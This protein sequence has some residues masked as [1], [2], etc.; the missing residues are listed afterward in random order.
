MAGSRT[1]KTSS[2]SPFSASGLKLPTPAQAALGRSF[3]GTARRFTVV[4]RTLAHYAG[5]EG[6]L[7]F[8]YWDKTDVTFV[9]LR[10]EGAD[11]AT[12]DYS[13]EAPVLYIGKAVDFDDAAAEERAHVRGLVDDAGRHE[14]AGASQRALVNCPNCGAATAV[15]TFGH[16]VNVVC[17]SCRSILDAANPGVT[18]LQ[19]YTE[20]T[21]ASSR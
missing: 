14:A 11:F 1:R 7:P 6:E 5:V 21:F 12:I 8:E 13:D 16:A 15:R 10:S 19:K 18:I 20:A 2:P 3:S 4:S 9:D 17:Q